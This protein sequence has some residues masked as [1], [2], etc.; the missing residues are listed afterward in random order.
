MLYIEWS[1][2]NFCSFSGYFSLISLFMC[3]YLCAFPL[4]DRLASG[5]VFIYYP[6]N[7]LLGLFIVSLFLFPSLL[8]SA[9]NIINFFWFCWFHFILFKH[10]DPNAK[11]IYLLFAIYLFPFAYIR[12]NISFLLSTVSYIP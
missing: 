1:K 6:P 7:H 8:M 9:F 11:L 12:T 3:L 5:S 4:F 2:V 10:L